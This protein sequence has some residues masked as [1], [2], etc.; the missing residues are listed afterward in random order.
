[1]KE[2]KKQVNMR[3]E[4]RTF[5]PF[6]FAQTLRNGQIVILLLMLLLWLALRGA[7][8]F[9]VFLNDPLSLIGKLCLFA[10]SVW[11]L[12]VAKEALRCL[13]F[14]FLAGAQWDYIKFGIFFSRGGAVFGKCMAAVNASGYRWAVILPCLLL[15]WVPAVLSLFWGNLWLY[16]AFAILF[17]GT[18]GD[19]RVLWSL[20]GLPAG[21]WVQDSPF[22]PGCDVYIPEA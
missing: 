14:H 22:A 6:R 16:S 20:R 17:A 1:M 18:W 9:S 8:D 11:L 5:D 4:S 3:P 10:V 13:G 12:S 15:G 19:L 2:K 7:P 21:S